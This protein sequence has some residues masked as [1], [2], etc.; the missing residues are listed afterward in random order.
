MAELT[1]GVIPGSVEYFLIKD[2]IITEEQLSKA[3]ESQKET[4]RTLQSELVALGFCTELDVAKALEKK[5]GFKLVSIEEVGI[6]FAV[7]NIIPADLVSKKG[8]LPLSQEDKKLFVVMI[9]Y[10]AP[11]CIVLILI[12]SVLDVLGIVKI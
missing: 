3:H 4:K 10:V 11:V 5:T 6:N 9:K 2:G 7:A 12:S 1:F 8:I